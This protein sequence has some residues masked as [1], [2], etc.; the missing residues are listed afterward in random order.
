MAIWLKL[1]G[2]WSCDFYMKNDNLV[3]VFR[4]NHSLLPCNINGWILQLLALYLNLRLPKISKTICSRMLVFI[5][6]KKVED[7]KKE[8]Y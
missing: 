1:T 8:N 2:Q 4:L 3:T 7:I 6:N 5:K